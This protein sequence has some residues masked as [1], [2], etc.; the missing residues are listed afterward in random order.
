LKRYCRNPN[1]ILWD[2]MILIFVLTFNRPGEQAT[3]T[4]EFARLLLHRRP[5]SQ[6]GM[7]GMS[8]HVPFQFFSGFCIGTRRIGNVFCDVGIAIEHPQR[9]QIFDDL[10]PEEKSFGFK[11]DCIRL[12]HFS[13]SFIVLAAAYI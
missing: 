2:E 7:F 3:A 4:D 10:A 13:K 6:F 12:C 5:K 8:V 1:F 11:D 9:I